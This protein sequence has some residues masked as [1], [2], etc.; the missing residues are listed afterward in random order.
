MADTIRKGFLKVKK[1]NEFVIAHPETEAA[2]I[3]D[4]QEGITHIMQDSTSFTRATSTVSGLMAKEDKV[5]LDGIEEGAKKV[6]KTAIKVGTDT[7]FRTGDINVTKEQLAIDTSYY[8]EYIVKEP[9]FFTN[10]LYG[11]PINYIYTFDLFQHNDI[12]YDI[13]ILPYLDFTQKKFVSDYL[14][15]NNRI[16]DYAFQQKYEE[17]WHGDWHRS[18]DGYQQEISLLQSMGLEILDNA[19]CHNIHFRGK[20]LTEAYTNHTLYANIANGSFHDIFPGDILRKTMQVDGII[21]ENATWMVVGCDF[22]YG[23]NG[24]N[25]HHIVLILI[26]DGFTNPGE[27]N[28]AGIYGEKQVM[29]SLYKYTETNFWIKIMNERYK[30]AITDAFGASHVLVHKEYETMIYNQQPFQSGLYDVT[31]NVLD[32]CN[33]NPLTYNATRRLNLS[34]YKEGEQYGHPYNMITIKPYVHQ[35]IVYTDKINTG[36]HYTINPYFCLY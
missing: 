30:N 34:V 19:D 7:V 33:C 4:L 16:D 36:L 2:Q 23:E 29:N 27:L 9:G 32:N 31:V 20:D 12:L 21:V 22:F 28:N 25:T 6:E 15:E 3:V 11:Y 10:P 24:C 13:K 18:G 14:I 35:S 1:N 17:K 8:P 5:K 26:D